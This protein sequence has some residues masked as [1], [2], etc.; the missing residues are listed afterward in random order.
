MFDV[1]PHATRFGVLEGDRSHEFSPLKNG[2]DAGKFCPATC[3]S[4]LLRLHRSYLVDAGA[5]FEGATDGPACEISPLV[6]Y[7]GEGLDAYKDSK[8]LA[9]SVHLE[10]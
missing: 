2:P 10:R 8:Q 9:H 6:S 5:V 4:D 3:R 1:F 7:A